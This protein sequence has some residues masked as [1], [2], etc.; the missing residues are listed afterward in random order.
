MFEVW[1]KEYIANL[2][3][4]SGNRFVLVGVGGRKLYKFWQ[5][6]S[7]KTVG[8]DLK[9]IF[10]SGTLKRRDPEKVVKSAG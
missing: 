4:L 6:S 2:F 7:L 10:G 1:T 9:A 5:E 3:C 8:Q